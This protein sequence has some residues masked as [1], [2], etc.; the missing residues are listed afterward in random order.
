MY[1]VAD[2]N[3]LYQ[4]NYCERH[5][6]TSYKRVSNGIILA[7]PFGLMNENTLLLSTRPGLFLLTNF[8]ANANA[9]SFL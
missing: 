2:N 4:F 5:L 1:C 8:F 7:Q 3:I 6:R 9:L